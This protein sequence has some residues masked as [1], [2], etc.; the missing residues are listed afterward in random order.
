VALS[1]GTQDEDT[2]ASIAAGM[3]SRVVNLCGRIPLNRLAALIQES[4]LLIGNDSAPIHIATA[5]NT[6]VIALFGPTPYQAWQPRRPH[7]RVLDI[8]VACPCRP[9]GHSRPDCPL[10][11]AGYC[12]AHI[13]EAQVWQAVEEILAH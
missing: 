12:M 11:R 10:G 1:G 3:K 9:C 8:P 6:P 2:C 5:V 4:T 7:D 13:T